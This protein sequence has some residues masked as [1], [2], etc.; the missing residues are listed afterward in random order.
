MG[1]RTPPEKLPKVNARFSGAYGYASL[2]GPVIS[3]FG[4]DIMESLGYLGWA[5]P[6]LAG[7]TLGLL[8]PLV[9]WDRRF[10]S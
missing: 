5:V 6:G 10:C 3:A 8:L 9:I 2:A 1:D 7:L 4:I